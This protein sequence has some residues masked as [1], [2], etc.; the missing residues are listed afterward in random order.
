MRNETLLGGAVLLFGAAVVGLVAWRVSGRQTVESEHAR[1]RRVYVALSL[2]EAAHDVQPAPNLLATKPYLETSDSL[3]SPRD[4]YMATRAA[5]FPTDPGLPEGRRSAPERISFSYL[6]AFR[7][8]GAVR[9]KPWS[10]T[11]A[12]ARVGL[13]AS[14]WLGEIEPLG[15][16]QAAVSGPVARLSTEG[17]ALRVARP[18]AQ[19]LGNAETLFFAPPERR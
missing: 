14:E 10:V 3:R 4:P 2:Y 11:R 17:A 19:R 13:L 6:W 15:N 12:D 1:L 18:G 9:V 8:Q 16:F 7:S 5:R